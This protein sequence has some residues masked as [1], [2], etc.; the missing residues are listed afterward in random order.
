MLVNNK[1]EMK[2]TQAGAIKCFLKMENNRE[3]PFIKVIMIYKIKNDKMSVSLQY[4]NRKC[5]KNFEELKK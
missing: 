5:F 2:K 3:L 4:V 1:S